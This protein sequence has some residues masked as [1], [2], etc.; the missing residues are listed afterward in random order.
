MRSI[1][2]EQIAVLIVLILWPLLSF[3]G[4]WM[5]RRAESRAPVEEPP[6]RVR[7]RARLPVAR[8]PA[9]RAPE[10]LSPRSEP[11]VMVTPPRRR[12]RSVLGSP[13]DLRRAIV[14]MTVLGPCRALE[15]PDV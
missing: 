2:P 7:E 3:L 5:K 1:S 11:P 12:R 6:A 9:A 14:V 15:R 8:P 10:R 13:R 4:R